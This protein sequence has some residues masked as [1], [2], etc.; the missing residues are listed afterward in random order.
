MAALTR[1]HIQVLLDQPGDRGMVISCYADTSVAEGFQAHWLQPFKTEASRIRQLFAEDHRS[2]LEF[3]RDLEAI[4]QALEPPEARQARGMAVFSAAARDFFLALLSEV[5]FENRLVVG[6]EPYVVPLVEA[7]LREQ[8]YLVILADTH[9]AALYGAGP[10]GSRLLDA[11]DEFVPR[12]QH[13]AGERWGKQQA[14]IERH[15]KDHILHFHKELARRVEQAWDEHPY[16]GMILLGH[17]EVLEQF[18]SLLPQRLADRV[19]HEAPHAWTEGHAEIDAKVRAVLVAAQAAQERSILDQLKSRIAE[20]CA[21]VTGP[22]EVI[23]AL[24]NGQVSELII[25]PDPGTVASRCD[26]CR[27]LFA[28]KRG[29]CPYC[30]APC[31][32]CNL[33]QEILALAMGHGVWVNLVKTSAELAPHGGI[34]ALLARAQPQWVPITPMT[35]EGEGAG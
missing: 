6:D 22:Q 23:E 19:V 8:G 12:K 1:E 31:R 20:G 15:R 7:Y 10:G 25:G 32:A 30:G 34:A 24:R 2:R 13:S 5:P 14:T 17:R 27:S 28:T 3:E 26:S 33:W 4:R 21:V 9:R 18:R 16:L 35:R 29:T 11:I